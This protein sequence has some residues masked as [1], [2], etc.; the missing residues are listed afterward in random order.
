MDPFER[1]I[2]RRKPVGALKLLVA[3]GLIMLA[4]NVL[5]QLLNLLPSGLNRAVS[6]A[7]IIFSFAVVWKLIAH[8]GESFTYKIS[9]EQGLFVIERQMGRSSTSF[10]SLN[11]RDVLEIRAYDPDQDRK[12]PGKRRFTVSRH[13][14]SWQVLSFKAAE[15][16]KLIF[17]PSDSFLD[18]L[19]SHIA[20]EKVKS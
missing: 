9:K 1:E 20:R 12:I 8:N 2:V 5:V 3:I 19:S 14:S 6:V 16:E 10:F 7:V 18:N 4:V 11:L 17:E 15:P 13:K